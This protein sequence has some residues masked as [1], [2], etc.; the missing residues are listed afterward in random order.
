MSHVL[1]F[2][3]GTKSIGVAI[4]NTLIHSAQPLP[5][6]S[7]QAGQPQW[8]KIALLLE[9]WSPEH[10]IVGLP[11]N[12]DDT[13]N[14]TTVQARTFANKLTGRFH[15]KAQ[16]VDERLSTFEAKQRLKESKKSYTKGELD[17]LSACLILESWY[18][19]L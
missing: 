18:A 3:F 11:L 13:D 14:P 9:K 1:C 17:S 8:N 16:L 4:G 10:L 2:D 15:I 5:A 6:L 19:V 7:A 12:M